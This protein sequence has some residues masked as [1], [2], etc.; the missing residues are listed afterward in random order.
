MANADRDEQTKERGD[1][2]EVSEVSSVEGEE[3]RP[4]IPG[5]ES[6]IGGS[7]EV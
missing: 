1:D 2:E 7:E 5:R 6:I 4:T 3:H